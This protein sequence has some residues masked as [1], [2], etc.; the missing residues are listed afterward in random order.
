VNGKW[1]RK[2]G[3]TC[4]RII[5]KNNVAGLIVNNTVLMGSTGRVTLE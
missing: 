5:V 3:D 2:N 1:N 4:G